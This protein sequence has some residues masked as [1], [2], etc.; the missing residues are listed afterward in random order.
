MFDNVQVGPV[1]VLPTLPT[2]TVTRTGTGGGTVTSSPAGI[3]CAP[4]CVANFASGTPVT[5][6]ATPDGASKFDGWS[7]DADCS[8][9]HVTM[10]EPLSCMPMFTASLIQDVTPP[11]IFLTSPTKGSTLSG[12]VNIIATATDNIGVVGVQ[13]RLNG[14]NLGAEDT[15][16]PFSISWNTTGVSPGQYT[17]TAIARDAAGN[18]TS[19]APLTINISSPASTLSVSIGGSGSVTSSPNGILCTSGTCSASYGNGSTITLIAKADKKWNFSGWSG[20]C[21]GTGECTILLSANQFV[22]ATF[23]P[24]GN[25]RGNK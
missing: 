18:S 23:S 21:S 16:D 6:T 19:S 1:D 22:G 10:T 3:T 17:L 13:F 11:S 8:D 2:L 9:G 4:S 24:N 12:T 20:A 5:L 15:T 25:G 7:G 14:A